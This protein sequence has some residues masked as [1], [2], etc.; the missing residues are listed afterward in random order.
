M[1][2]TLKGPKTTS[3]NFRNSSKPRE[4]L[5]GST[6]I[7]IYI[8]IY[9]YIFTEYTLNIGNYNYESKL[10]QLDPFVYLPMWFFIKK[11]FKT[12]TERR[13]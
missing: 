7:Y 1:F 5:T 11:Q 2:Q 12:I 13:S 6:K 8:Y 3:W 4:V 9:I 10:L